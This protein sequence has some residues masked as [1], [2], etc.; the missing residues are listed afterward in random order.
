VLLVAAVVAL[1][2]VVVSL[3]WTPLPGV[4][5]AALAVE[6]AMRELDAH[7]LGWHTVLYAAGLLLLCELIAWA[8]TLRSRALVAPDVVGRRAGNMLLGVLAGGGAAGLAVA[9]GS[10]E[11]PNAFVAGVAGAAAVAALVGVVWSLGRRHA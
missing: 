6:F 11:S 7:V 3:V 5:L 2:A 10:I 9:A 1:V 4:V 8:D